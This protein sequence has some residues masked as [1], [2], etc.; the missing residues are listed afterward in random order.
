MLQS[1]LS[2][3][4]NSLRQSKLLNNEQL[5][6]FLDLFMHYEQGDSVYPGVIKRH[7]GIDSELAYKI[8]GLL[9]DEGM[10]KGYFEINCFECNRAVGDLYPSLNEIPEFIYCPNCQREIVA[11][12]NAVLIFKVI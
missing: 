9:E 7:L 12:N 8:L 3:I 2:D 5:N 10:L 4:G 6:T 11:I 1:I